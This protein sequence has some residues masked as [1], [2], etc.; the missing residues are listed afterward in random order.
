[1]DTWKWLVEWTENEEGHDGI[2]AFVSTGMGSTWVPELHSQWMSLAESKAGPRLASPVCF[3]GGYPPGAGDRYTPGVLRRGITGFQPVDITA[4]LCATSDGPVL[5]SVPRRYSRG[6]SSSRPHG[7]VH[8]TPLVTRWN[9]RQPR[10]AV[11]QSSGRARSPAC[12]DST[13]GKA[14]ARTHPGEQ[15]LDKR[16]TVTARTT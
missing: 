1:L 15:V 14:E 9:P 6:P 4:S 8:R 13:K 2:E 12:V 10:P 3:P 11:R 5:V 7:R 16:P